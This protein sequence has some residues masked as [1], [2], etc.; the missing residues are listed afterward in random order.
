MILLIAQVNK[1][2]RRKDKFK[3]ERHIIIIPGHRFKKNLLKVSQFSKNNLSKFISYEIFLPIVQPS[4]S[5]SQNHVLF[6]YRKSLNAKHTKQL[7]FLKL[8]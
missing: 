5:P 6:F 4:P 1:N 8:G 3:D 2:T 7:G